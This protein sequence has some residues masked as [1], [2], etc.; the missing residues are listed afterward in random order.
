MPKLRYQSGGYNISTR[1]PFGKRREAYYIRQPNDCFVRDSDIAVFFVTVRSCAKQPFIVGTFKFRSESL[2]TA[3][4]QSPDK[5]AQM[6]G[7][8]PK[9][10][11]KWSILQGNFAGFPLAQ[12]ADPR[13]L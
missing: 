10:P 1:H 4:Y 8:S 2:L 6:T 11:C 5:I 9:P 13:T 7:L 12:Y 3:P